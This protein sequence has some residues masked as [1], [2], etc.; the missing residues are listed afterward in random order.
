MQTVRVVALINVIGVAL[1]G[2][3]FLEHFPRAYPRAS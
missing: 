2:Q 1:A 3:M